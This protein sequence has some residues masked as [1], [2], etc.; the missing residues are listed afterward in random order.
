[1]SIFADM[2]RWRAT[3]EQGLIQFPRPVIVKLLEQFASPDLKKLGFARSTPGCWVRRKKA[4]ILEVVE[5][6]TYG[7]K[8]N[9]VFGVA[10]PFVPAIR[11]SRVVLP[12]NPEKH[13]PL[14]PLPGFE[15]DDFPDDFSSVQPRSELLAE[16]IRKRVPAWL[17]VFREAFNSYRGLPSLCQR[18]IEIRREFPERRPTDALESPL[19][20]A[21]AFVHARLGEK[22]EAEAVLESTLKHKKDLRPYAARLRK[23]LAETRPPGR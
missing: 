20:L 18:L 8:A 21:L 6:W 13:A 19:Y 22:E 2:A 11:G 14:I 10:L 1:M 7:I 16:D 17:K 9:L 23:M 4:P 3:G 5:V 15:R 12:S